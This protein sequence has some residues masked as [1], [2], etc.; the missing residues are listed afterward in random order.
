MRI[1][2]EAIWPEIIA[3]ASR[4]HARI[5]RSMIDHP[6]LRMAAER[7]CLD[8]EVAEKTADTMRDGRELAALAAQALRSWLA[9]N[10]ADGVPVPSWDGDVAKLAW[11]LLRRYLEARSG[12]PPFDRSPNPERIPAH[13]EAKTDSRGLFSGPPSREPKSPPGRGRPD[14]EAAEAQRALVKVLRRAVPRR[15]IRWNSGY[16]SGSAIDLER[17]MRA[18]A[19]GR[20]GD[21]IWLRR[22][23]EGP[24]LAA[25]LL[26]DLSGSMAGKKVKAAIAVT[27][28]LSAAMAEVRG[29]AWCVLGFQDKTI[30]FVRFEERADTRVLARID[31]MDAEVVGNRQGGNNQ[32]RYNDDGPC[33]LD[34]AA[35]LRARSER[36]R[37][38]MVISDGR[39]E[40][41]RSSHD[42]LHRAVAQVQA[43]R[44][45]MLVG[46]GLGPSTDH[47]T[48]Y[49]PVSQANIELGS[50]APTIGRLLASGL[51]GAA[52]E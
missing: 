36:D 45:M 44:G 27:R 50:L 32:P 46:L 23:D 8:D 35:Q 6:D 39:P 12:Q 24:A 37:L 20:D 10:G 48:S 52:H 38:L 14:D 42:D 47:V 28:A 2:M 21:R 13:A 7:N 17:V 11:G 31:E 9:A 4:D 33:L 40:G 19:A 15:R 5:A 18:T 25:L 34:A 41:R 1:F 3:L 22:T 16:R 26:V 30:P 43:M 29:I 49:Y 51:R